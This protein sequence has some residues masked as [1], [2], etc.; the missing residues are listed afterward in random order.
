MRRP[1]GFSFSLRV[2]IGLS[3]LLL[4][5]AASAAAQTQTLS[6][7]AV[8]RTLVKG[9][10]I[11]APGVYIEITGAKGEQEP[12]YRP[13]QVS[14]GDREPEWGGHYYDAAPQ[15]GYVTSQYGY[16]GDRGTRVSRSYGGRSEGRFAGGYGGHGAGRGRGHR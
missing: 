4:F 10:K 1:P 2:A 13:E 12:V 9:T 7:V 11:E 5:A 15:Y 16:G 6:D 3:A 8:N 14:A